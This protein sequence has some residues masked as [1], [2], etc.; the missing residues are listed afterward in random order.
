MW[1]VSANLI[2]S[3]AAVLTTIA[4]IPQAYSA[5]KTRDLSGIS[6]AMYS[7]FTV[8]VALWLVYGCLL[9]DMPLILSNTVTLLLSLIILGLKIQQVCKK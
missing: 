6:L 7:I 3:I 5:W 1:N 9:Q 2:G 4:F 8:G